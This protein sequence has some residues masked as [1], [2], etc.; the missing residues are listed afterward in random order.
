[1]RG[2]DVTHV[3]LFFSFTFHRKFYPCA[4]VHW[5]S[6]VGDDPDDDMGMWIVK[7][8]EGAGGAPSVA[9]LHLDIIAHAAHLIG[10]YG[11]DFLSGGTLTPEQS[12]CLFHAYYFI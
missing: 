11:V 1:M 6:L 5:Y 3:H 2:L 7:V 4:L 12:L 10:I 8:D 9:V